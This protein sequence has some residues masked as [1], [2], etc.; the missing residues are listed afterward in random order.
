MGMKV[1]T[2]GHKYDDSLQDCPFCPK[3]K[4]GLNSTVIGDPGMEATR[5]FD[6]GGMATK[7][8]NEAPQGFQQPPPQQN[9]DSMKTR[10]GLSPQNSNDTGP[11]A[12]NKTTETYKLIGWLVTFS[13]NPTGDDYKIR[14]GKTHIGS[15][16]NSDIKLT[17]PIASSKHATLLYRNNVLKIKDNFS[18]NGT[19]VN[20]DDIDEE[21]HVLSDGDVI[22]LGSTE[23]LLRLIEIPG[24]Q[25]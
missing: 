10:I 3:N 2:N 20:N 9:N 5:A 8:L 24:E 19:F 18:T 13:W 22:K 25:Q 6:N 15:D 4:G 17:D 12:I 7:I 21:A 1:C 11:V 14:E 16:V 23:F